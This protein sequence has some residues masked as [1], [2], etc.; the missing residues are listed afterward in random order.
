MWSAQVFTWTVVIIATTG[1]VNGGCHGKFKAIPGHS[2]CLN[3]SPKVSVSGISASEKTEITRLH[4]TYRQKVKNALYMHKV[5]WDDEV[6]MVAKKWAENCNLNHD[7]ISARF[8]PGRFS[9]GQNIA[10]GAANSKRNWTSIVDL[11]YN[12]KSSFTYG[13]SNQLG[14]VGHY[15]Q[16]VWADTY[17]VGCGFALCGNTPFYVCDYG[18]SGNIGQHDRPYQSGTSTGLL[19]C[20]GISCYGDRKLTQSCT[21]ACDS[22]LLP[23]FTGGNTCQLNCGVKDV[24]TTC[25]PSGT[26]KQTDCAKIFV[27]FYCPHMCKTCPY[28]DPSYSKAAG[29]I[30]SHWFLS[31]ICL[32]SI[33]VA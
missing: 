8:I 16:L 11:W 33:K 19:D 3:K 24:S 21:C 14:Q 2:A 12:E 1:L 4:N 22:K 13:G 5:T 29:Y 18:P 23:A 10:M 25:G 27:T 31:L 15:T 20:G 9:V 32:I 28:A 26:Y 30:T 6:A 17:L 7:Q